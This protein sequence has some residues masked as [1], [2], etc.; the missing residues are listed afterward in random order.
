M[1]RS[2]VFV[3]VLFSVLAL[4]GTSHAQP[5]L[6][7]VIQ[8]DGY[9]QQT[10]PPAQAVTAD[11]LIVV[12]CIVATNVYI[13][14]FDKYGTPVAGSYLYNGGSAGP[15]VPANGFRWITLGMIVPRATQDPWGFAGGEKFTFR[16]SAST[17]FRP[18]IVEVKQ[19]VYTSPQTQGPGEAIWNAENFKT[20]SEAALGGMRGTGLVNVKNTAPWY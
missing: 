16:I 11:T 18:I 6:Q 1:K 9:L 8:Y 3:T 14:V 10:A 5:Y 12:S 13:E 2:L 17:K 7:Q 4:A 20:W 15:A 19:V